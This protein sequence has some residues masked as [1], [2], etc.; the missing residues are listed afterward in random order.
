MNSNTHRSIGESN[1]SLMEDYCVGFNNKGCMSSDENKVYGTYLGSVYGYH[2]FFRK[3]GRKLLKYTYPVGY[4]SGCIFCPKGYSWENLVPARFE[5]EV[6]DSL[7]KERILE[8]M[9]K[10]KIL[11]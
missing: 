2:V 5:G 1:L 7:G 3:A 6:T 8:T 10:G 4:E 11:Q 9:K